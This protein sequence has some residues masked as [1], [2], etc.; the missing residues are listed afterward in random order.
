M[1]FRCDA[2]FEQNKTESTTWLGMTGCSELELLGLLP[3]VLGV[4]KVTV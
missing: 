4:A 1:N 2:E 3:S